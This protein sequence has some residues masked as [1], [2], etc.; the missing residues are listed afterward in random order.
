MSPVN[1]IPFE[2]VFGRPAPDLW[3]FDFALPSRHWPFEDMRDIMSASR[4]H[5]Q[6]RTRDSALAGSKMSFSPGDRVIRYIKVSKPGSMKSVPHPNKILSLSHA[7]GRG[8]WIAYDDNGVVYKVPEYQLKRIEDSN[9]L[10]VN[11]PSDVDDPILFHPFQ[12]GEYL[13]VEEVID[14]DWSYGVYKLI[15]VVQGDEDRISVVQGDKDKLVCSKLWWTSPKPSAQPIWKEYP[16]EPLETI[17]PN[18]VIANRV[19]LNNGRISQSLF[20]RLKGFTK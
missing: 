20:K 2:L 10:R 4:Q 6:E 11:L 12:I 1:V 9:D 8:Q 19:A 17:L 3:R 16:D 15:S 5:L 7:V 18:R 14:E 13:I